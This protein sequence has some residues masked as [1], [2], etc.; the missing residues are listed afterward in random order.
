M[1][2]GCRTRTVDVISVAYFDR[3]DGR[4]TRCQGSSNGLLDSGVIGKKGAMPEPVAIFSLISITFKYVGSPYVYLCLDIG[5][6]SPCH[7]CKRMLALSQIPKSEEVVGSAFPGHKN[8]SL[9]FINGNTIYLSQFP[10]VSR[11][12]SNPFNRWFDQTACE[13]RKL[14]HEMRLRGGSSEAGAEP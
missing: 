4:R 12:S 11:C 13:I 14:G 8:L 2:P 10:R 5:R 1:V 9:A 6:T 3:M 7:R